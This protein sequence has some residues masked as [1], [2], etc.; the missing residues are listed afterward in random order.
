MRLLD[1]LRRPKAVPV[2]DARLGELLFHRSDEVMRPSIERE[3]VWEFR[4]GMWLDHV[5]GPG[6]TFLNVGANV[7]YFAVW[8][9]QIVGESGRVHALEPDPD[10]FSLLTR[11]L[12]AAGMSSFVFAHQRAAG[13]RTEPMELFCSPENPGDHRVYL[14]GDREQ[15]SHTVQCWQIDEAVGAGWLD[16]P[17]LD[18]VLVDAQGWDHQVL[19]GMAAVIDSERPVIVCEL[20]AEVNRGT[21]ER[22]ADILTYWQERNYRVGVLDM[23]A[24]PGQLPAAEILRVLDHPTVP[25][26]NLELWPQEKEFLPGAIPSNGFSRP[27]P[28]AGSRGSRSWLTSDRGDIVVRGGRGDELRVTF[29]LAPPPGFDASVTIG[30]TE[31]II[32]ETTHF[33]H[34]IRIGAQGYERL[35]FSSASPGRHIGADPRPLRCAVLSP[36]AER[37]S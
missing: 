4:V 13:R 23:G 14:D 8:A 6:M 1:R 11:N 5:L 37:I 34:R 27:E 10:N 19:Q 26:L 18:V 7:G 30:E 36:V 20:M 33:E 21:G 17:S 35:P 9:G 29:G 24:A 32:G 28:L 12:E 16:M 15:V 31:R 2:A 25:Y 22:P 3:S